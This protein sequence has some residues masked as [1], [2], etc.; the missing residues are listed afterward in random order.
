M[1]LEELHDLRIILKGGGTIITKNVRDWKFGPDSYTIKWPK[2][3]QQNIGWIDPKEIAGVEI[4]KRKL[5]LCG[6]KHES[7]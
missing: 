5:R 7:E 2:K 1:K 4:I 3:S 6:G